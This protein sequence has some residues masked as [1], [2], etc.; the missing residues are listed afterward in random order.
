MGLRDKLIEELETILK[1]QEEAGDFDHTKDEFNFDTAFVRCT[2]NNFLYRNVVKD[3]EYHNDLMYIAY[4]IHREKQR[5][6]S[7]AE[8]K[9]IIQLIKEKRDD[10][11]RDMMMRHYQDVVI[12][13]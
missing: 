7:L 8:H 2:G 12:D 1:N 4:Q 10:E 9:A 13:N 3:F 5:T 11:F 6:K